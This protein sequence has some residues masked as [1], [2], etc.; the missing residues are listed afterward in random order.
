[1]R[2]MRAALL[3]AAIAVLSSPAQAQ[4]KTVGVWNVDLG[5]VCGI[6][7]AWKAEAGNAIAWGINYVDKGKGLLLWFADTDTVF[8]PKEDLKLALQVDKKW[9]KNN[10]AAFAFDKNT[11][12]TLFEASGE[13]ITALMTG[14]NLEMTMQ[15]KPDNYS[16]T[17][18]LDDTR[19]AIAAL[20]ACKAT[21][22]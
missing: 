13:S 2:A 4:T 20:D 1:M 21:A 11:A 10:V 12:A 5:K 8:T 6:T 15:D 3:C 16:G 7:Q 9:K 22:D 18:S 19:Q 14:K 17:F